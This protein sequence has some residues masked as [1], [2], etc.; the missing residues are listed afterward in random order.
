MSPSRSETL[1]TASMLY[2]YIR[3]PTRLELD[4]F[5]DSSKKDPISPFVQML[6]ERGHLYED[7]V[8]SIPGVEPGR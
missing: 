3:C 7:E 4:F 5:E 1:I 8:L 2:D 6:W